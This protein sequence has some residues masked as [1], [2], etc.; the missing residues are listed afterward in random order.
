MKIYQLETVIC[1]G[2]GMYLVSLLV[3]IDLTKLR[4]GHNTSNIRMDIY[5]FIYIYIYIYIYKL[6]TSLVEC[7]ITNILL[8][9]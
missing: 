1:V 2:M 9:N 3:W 7:Y 4:N 5:K 6:L 8:V